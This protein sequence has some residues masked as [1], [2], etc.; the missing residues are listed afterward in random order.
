MT[1]MQNYS[2]QMDNQEGE[3]EG[4]QGDRSAQFNVGGLKVDAVEA[5]GKSSCDRQSDSSC[6]LSRRSKTA[7]DNKAQKR[8]KK[9]QGK[10]SCN[11]LEDSASKKSNKSLA[12]LKSQSSLA[13]SKKSLFSDSQRSKRRTVFRQLSQISCRSGDVN[14]V[15][16]P[17]ENEPSEHGSTRQQPEYNATKAADLN[18]VEEHDAESQVSPLPIT[19]MA[20]KK[21]SKANIKASSPKATPKGAGRTP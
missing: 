14:T 11:L 9:R 8:G 18:I 15:E 5:G 17:N 13:K 10:S 3:E 1:T 16:K 20:R 12:E 21:E 19:K 4:K 6:K 7:P 2:S